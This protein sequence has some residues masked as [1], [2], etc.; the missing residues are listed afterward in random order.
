MKLPLK[1]GIPKCFFMTFLNSGSST[2]RI[3]FLFSKTRGHQHYRTCLMFTRKTQNRV[4]SSE[5]QFI[6]EFRHFNHLMLSND[7]FSFFFVVFFDDAL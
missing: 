6:S 5:L 2:I 4:T 1:G 7:L 3:L